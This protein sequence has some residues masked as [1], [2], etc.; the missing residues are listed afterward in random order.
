MAT[1]EHKIPSSVPQFLP[2][3]KES[4]SQLQ[5]EFNVHVQTIDHLKNRLKERAMVTETIKIRFQ[6]EIE[7]LVRQMVAKRMELVQLL[8]TAYGQ[9]NFPQ[10]EQEKLASFI[11][12]QASALVQQYAV[13]EMAELLSKYTNPSPR[14]PGAPAKKETQQLLKHVLGLEVELQDMA[15]VEAL[16]A[17]LD[18]QMQEEQNRREA[19]RAQRQQ[20]LAHQTKVTR[21]KQELQEISKA[22]RKLYTTLAKLLHPDTEREETA[23]LWKEEAMKKVT[24]AYHQDDFFELLRLQMEFMHGQEQVLAQVPEDQLTYYVRLLREQIEELE[25][26]QGTYFLGPDAKLYQEFGGTPKQIEAKFRA[27]KKT[28]KEEI[29]Q[30]TAATREFED[31]AILRT[32]LKQVEA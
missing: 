17:R 21:A 5:K 15:D 31:P 19:Q 9:N 29:A 14:N 22:S 32:F 24:I 10:L 11:K 12:S 8:D 4:P 7:P 20:Y 1:S 25:D 16:Q 23:R 30:V 6:K 3:E 26:A 13:P 28:L 2:Q 18:Q 27:A